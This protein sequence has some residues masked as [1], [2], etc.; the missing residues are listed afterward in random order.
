WSRDGKRIVFESDREGDRGLFWQ[1]AEGGAAERLTKSEPGVEHRPEAFTPDGKAL[2]F[3]ISPGGGADI[4][5]LQMDGDRKPKPLVELPGS[6]E[7]YTAFSPDGRWFAYSSTK[8]GPPDM[9]VFVQPF[10]PAGGKDYQISTGGARTP[11]WSPV[12]K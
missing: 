10:P 7:R 12:G 5:I 1:P 6:N 4:W 3:I 9:E 8:I 2:A 11:V